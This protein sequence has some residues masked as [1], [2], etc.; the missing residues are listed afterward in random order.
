MTY[1]RYVP[2]MLDL[3]GEGGVLRLPSYIFDVFVFDDLRLSILRKAQ[4]DLA[5]GHNVLITGA[6]GTGKTALMAMILRNVVELGYR[7]GYIV[8]SATYI[9]RDHED[10]GVIV[11]C[12]DISRLSKSA[13][14]S[15]VKN[16]VHLLVAT[17]RSEEMRELSLRLGVPARKVFRIYRL[18]PMSRDTL[19]EI[20]YRFADR[21]GI[22]V[23]RDAAEVVLSKSG[24][25]PIYIWQL[26]RDLKVNKRKVLDVEFANRIPQGMLEYIDNILWSILDEHEDKASILLTLMVMADTPTYELHQDLM[27]ILFAYLQHMVKG[28]ELDLKS[29]LLNPLLDRVTR[30]LFKTN[31]FTFKLPHDSWVDVLRG[32]SRGF[33]GS[34]ISRLQALYPKAKRREI[35]EK[36]ASV[37][38][39]YVI[40]N[41]TDEQRKKAFYT[42]LR[43]LGISIG[44]IDIDAFNTII[45]GLTLDMDELKKKLSELKREAD[46]EPTKKAT[47]LL[48][49]MA[50]HIRLNDRKAMSQT[51]DSLEK[52]LDKISPLDAHVI[53]ILRFIVLSKPENTVYSIKQIIKLYG[54][55]RFE[56]FSRL[57]IMNLP[58]ENISDLALA[59]YWAD[60]RLAEKIF[61]MDAKEFTYFIQKSNIQDVFTEISDIYRKIPKFADRLIDSH[62]GMLADK[63]E[64]LSLHEKLSIWKILNKLSKR[65]VGRMTQIIK[66]LLLEV[67][68]IEKLGLDELL[69]YISALQRVSHI[70]TTKYLWGDAIRRVLVEKI[71]R[72]E[73]HDDMV[74]ALKVISKL[75]TIASKHGCQQCVG[76]CGE[77]EKTI[78]RN[79][80]G[81]SESKLFRLI[82][83]IGRT[84]LKSLRIFP[85]M[86]AGLLVERITGDPDLFAKLRRIAERDWD[87]LM[88]GI[89]LRVTSK[90]L[91]GGVIEPLEVTKF[92]HNL[93][94]RLS[95]KEYF[96]DLS[97]IFMDMISHYA[98]R[99][100]SL[101]IA[102]L[103]VLA[104]NIGVLRKI[105]SHERVRLD[106]DSMERFDPMALSMI[107]IGLSNEPNLLKTLCRIISR[108]LKTFLDQLDRDRKEHIKILL[109]TLLGDGEDV[110]KVLSGYM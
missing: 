18:M 41:I 17:V 8:E 96:D 68:E 43:T 28:Q 45:R 3:V 9:G 88:G 12:D 79:I 97:G 74:I 19:L 14:R 91:A 36:A 81:L 71:S 100:D 1:F 20:L 11:F 93:S 7:I 76:M 95:D 94:D 82:R 42:Q 102:T 104:K 86:L 70:K 29:A 67:E 62:W 46:K 108:H 47:Y 23:D 58:P 72:A 34:D 54:S 75:Y 59:I 99:N 101:A 48:Y 44:R 27:N 24:N 31:N 16:N 39:D 13:L 98:R 80:R 6:A 105:L 10:E 35:L 69:S 107:L 110:V 63:A 55:E 103:L 21:E 2:S 52:I 78:I 56:D 15:I 77:L 73:S 83:S 33:I 53:N 85:E 32:K 51:S 64:G 40:R 87:P 109:R 84:S 89:F 106:I 66:S 92:I 37:C 38:E 50:L 22:T 60:S 57:L 26:I 4:R 25:L 49:S 61:I 5:G 90:L 65:F 30:Y